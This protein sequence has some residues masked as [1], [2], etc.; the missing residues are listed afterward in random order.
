MRKLI[1]LALIVAAS[2]QAEPVR[3]DGGLFKQPIVGEQGI[4]YVEIAPF[5][6]DA[7]QVS[8]AQFLEFVTANPAWR[9]DR[10]PGVF[11]DK[12]Y[13][14]HWSGPLTL[15]EG[16]AAADRP[17]TRVSWFAARAYCESKGG[18]LAG[19]DEWEYAALR[20][21]QLSGQSGSEYAHELFAWYASPIA[22]GLRP[23]ASGKP[24]PLGLHDLHGLVLEWVEDY[25][26]VLGMGEEADLTTGSCGDTARFLPDID[27]EHYATFFR[28][29]SRSNYTPRT[30]TNTLG[31]R[32]AYDLE[33]PQ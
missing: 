26:L 6:L 14:S 5:A 18:R 23:V 1:V 29:Q 28:Y 9:R 2:A 11:A 33:M 24:G 27:E 20:Q 10:I 31:F 25:Q 32:C 30:T 16:A 3:I 8:N 17:V 13:L 22:D 21:R 4:Q 12:G 15:G 19:I 7:A